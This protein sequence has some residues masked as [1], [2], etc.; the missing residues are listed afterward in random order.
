MNLN[1]LHICLLAGSYALGVA[2]GVFGITTF[3]MAASGFFKGEKGADG[4][5]YYPTEWC[6]SE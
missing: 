3:A 6:E 4:K 5:D 2:G 1:K